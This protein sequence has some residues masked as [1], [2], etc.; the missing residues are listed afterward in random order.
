VLYYRGVN[1]SINPSRRSE[2]LEAIG[3]AAAGIAHDINN[4]LT[5]ILNHLPAPDRS[6]TD[7][8][9]VKAAAERCSSL[10]ASLLSWCRGETL[11]MAALDVAEFLEDYRQRLNLP[12]S[13]VFTLELPVGLPRIA[14]DRLSLQR[15]L[16]NLVSNACA[17]MKDCGHL[18]ISAS[19]GVIQV[20]DSGPGVPPSMQR[21]IF[22]PFVTSGVNQGTGLGL[23]IVREIMR[24]YGGSASI[25]PDQTSGATFL[26]RF[27]EL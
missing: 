9:T 5:L 1:S 21:R 15:V 8:E 23:A 20:S 4:Q 12:S 6:P 17:A 13:V 19:P 24:Q 11:V 2:R 16:D 22:N 26:L 10:T 18:C 7:M 3:L 27:R 25:Q 14:A